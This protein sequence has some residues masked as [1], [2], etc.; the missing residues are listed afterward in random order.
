MACPSQS[1][2]PHGCRD[3]AEAVARPQIQ[4]SDEP[5]AMTALINLKL[6]DNVQFQDRPGACK[7]IET[8][9]SRGDQAV[10]QRLAECQAN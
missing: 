5:G 8:A 1:G 9:A 4:A 7:L 10:I 3:A 2:Q 6:S